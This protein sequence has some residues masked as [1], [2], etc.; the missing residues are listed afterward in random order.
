MASVTGQWQFKFLAF[1][2][3]VV[4]GFLTGLRI[5]FWMVTHPFSWF[6]QKD[7]SGESCSL[8]LVARKM[9]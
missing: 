9:S 4:F 5:L 6:K 1:I 8:V 7:R 3:T 2:L